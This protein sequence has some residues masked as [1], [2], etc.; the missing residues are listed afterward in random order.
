MIKKGSFVR[1]SKVVLKSSERIK[2]LPQETREKDFVMWTK[3]V[4]CDDA[5]IGD[6]VKVITLSNREEIG[7][8][9]NVNHVQEVN[10]GHFLNET[11]KIG[12]YVKR[13]L[14]E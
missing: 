13:L 2:T 11:F 12:C 5:N 9:E 6:E 10:Y 4:L 14:D 8:L 7:I 3:G 1:I